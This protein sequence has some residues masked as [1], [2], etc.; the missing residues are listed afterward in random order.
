MNLE[1]PFGDVSVGGARVM[2]TLF[3]AAVDVA[4]WGVLFCVTVF[5]NYKRSF[6]HYVSL[7]LRWS[8]DTKKAIFATDVTGFI[9]EGQENVDL[10]FHSPY[11]LIA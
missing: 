2:C 3:G 1:K 8:T 4:C 11:L 9:A 6:Y 10:Y 5:C 7:A